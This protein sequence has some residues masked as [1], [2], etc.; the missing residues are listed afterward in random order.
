MRRLGFQN[1][2]QLRK[3][4]IITSSSS[5]LVPQETILSSHIHKPKTDHP[6]SFSFLRESNSSSSC[7]ICFSSD[8]SD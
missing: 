6:N 2:N 5:I 3:R 1:L 7:P 4:S 8:S